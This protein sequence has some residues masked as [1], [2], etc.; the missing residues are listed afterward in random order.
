MSRHSRSVRE[1][2]GMEEPLPPE[3]EAFCRIMARI[4]LRIKAEEAARTTERF[5]EDRKG[6]ESSPPMP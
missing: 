2:V 3:V 5:S 4:V 6:A 1:S